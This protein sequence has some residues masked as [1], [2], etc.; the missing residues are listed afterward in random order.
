MT[1]IMRRRVTH[2]RAGRSVRLRG[3]ESML[4]G[5]GAAPSRPAGNSTIPGTYNVGIAGLPL[6][7]LGSA[8]RAR[9]W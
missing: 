1:V 7:D 3:V 5:G 4:G 9:S 6:P 8:S 2:H